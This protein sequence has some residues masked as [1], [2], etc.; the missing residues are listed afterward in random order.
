MTLSKN[1]IYHFGILVSYL[2][3]FLET[4]I[5]IALSRSPCRKNSSM[6]FNAHVRDCS[7]VLAGL[8][9]SANLIAFQ[10]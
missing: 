9:K 3:R 10:K 4:G 7:V 2:S 6:T 1:L 8:F 5:P